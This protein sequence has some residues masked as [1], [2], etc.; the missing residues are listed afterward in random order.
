MGYRDFIFRNYE[1]TRE[2]YNYLLPVYGR[3]KADNGFRERPDDPFVTEKRDMCL[4]C[5]TPDDY[6]EMQE[7]C[8][9]L[10]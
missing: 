9:Y 5:G 7:R 1:I 6:K 4:F 3:C 8:K 10:H 2:Q